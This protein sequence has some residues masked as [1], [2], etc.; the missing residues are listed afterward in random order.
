MARFWP[1]LLLTLA[2]PLLAAPPVGY[3]K[4][5]VH[6]DFRLPTVSGGFQKL[7]DY[8]GKRVVLFNFA[9]W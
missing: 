5:H 3:A 8:R 2:G 9:S 6:P 1:A 4:G 7:S